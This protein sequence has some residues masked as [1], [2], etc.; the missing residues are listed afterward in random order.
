MTSNNVRFDLSPYL[1]H[2]FRKLDLDKADVNF[3]PEDWGPGEIVEDAAVTPLF[4]LRNAIRLQRLWATWSM[5]N[6]RRTV[7][8]PDPAVCFT[9]MPIAAFIEA[10]EA[11]AAKGEAMSPI[12]LVLP[13]DLV[14]AAG[15]RPVIYGLSTSGQLPSGDGGVPRVMPNSV[16]PEAEPYRYVTLG[17]YGSVDWT[18]ERE[19]RWPYRGDLPKFDDTPPC[20]GKDL[21]GLDL[22]FPGMGVIVRTKAQ[23]RKILHDVLVLKDQQAKGDFSFVLV[24]EDIASLSGL[25]E[26]S[27]VQ[28]ALSAAAITLDPFLNMAKSKRD[29][30][31]ADFDTAIADL[32]TTKVRDHGREEGGCWLWLTDATHEITRA[33]VI[34]DRVRINDQGRYL[35]ELPLDR[36]LSL[37]KREELTRR[38]AALLNERHGL[39]ATYHS[40]LGSFNFDEIPHYSVPPFENR[41]IFNFGSD[42]GDD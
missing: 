19:W 2:F 32:D 39:T 26:P 11:R 12:A 42:E 41:M 1:I 30:L 38:L 37:G 13:K 23:A 20:Y 40:V 17:T 27:E 6:G 21:P 7:Y 28:K 36:D 16:L 8:G 31:I 35:V 10:G 15:A 9:D 3:T 33:L 25:R 4:L 29:K 5:R 18:H 34:N 14:H 22:N 24:G